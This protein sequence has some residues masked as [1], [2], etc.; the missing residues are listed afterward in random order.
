MP[1]PSFSHCALT[2]IQVATWTAYSGKSGQRESLCVRG[3]RPDGQSAFANDGR[4]FFQ[5][6]ETSR[7]N[8]GGE[9]W[10]RCFNCFQIEPNE[11]RRQKMGTLNYFATFFDLRCLIKWTRKLTTN[12]GLLAG[13]AIDAMVGLC[14][15][16]GHPAD[17]GLTQGVGPAAGAHDGAVRPAAALPCRTPH[18]ALC[19]HAH[20][21]SNGGKSA[22]S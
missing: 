16:A 2:L 19:T 20:Q 5:R 12:D 6:D 3:K 13:P 21:T 15:S 9:V 10:S 22:G 4:S 8:G 14:A 11:G 7:R 18:S 1:P 17:M